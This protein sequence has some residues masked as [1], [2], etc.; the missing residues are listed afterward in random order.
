MLHVRHWLKLAAAEA[1]RRYRARG[2]KRG[3]IVADFLICADAL[4]S[5]CSGLRIVDPMMGWPMTALSYATLNRHINCAR[6]V[7]A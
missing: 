5:G 7:T 3:G 1:W 2:G 4:S 6:I